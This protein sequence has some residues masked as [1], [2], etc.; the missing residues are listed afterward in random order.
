MWLFWG[1]GEKRFQA[2]EAASAKALRRDLALL[3][4]ESG[5]R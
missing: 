4:R 5:R 3:A 1:S 2:K